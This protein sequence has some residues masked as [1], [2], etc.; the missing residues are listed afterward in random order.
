MWDKVSREIGRTLFRLPKGAFW[1][2]EVGLARGGRKCASVLSRLRI[3]IFGIRG[4]YAS[5]TRL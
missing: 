5:G 2:T 4:N 3:P 1:V